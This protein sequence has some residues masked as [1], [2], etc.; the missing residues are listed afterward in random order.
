MN[1][2]IP[3]HG[4]QLLNLYADEENLAAEKNKAQ[5]AQSW[6]LN[7]RQLCDVEL[8]LNGAFSPL[9]GF[10]TQ[11]DYESVLTSMRLANGILWPMPINLDVSAAFAQSITLDENIALRDGE[12]VVVAKMRVTY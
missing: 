8:L 4:G 5:H 1:Q 3:A 11:H 7:R 12:G 2:S 9:S 10:L 6:S